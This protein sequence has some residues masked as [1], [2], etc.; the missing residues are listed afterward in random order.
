MKNITK[1]FIH[2][3]YSKKGISLIVLLL[4]I[5]V[6]IILI[7]TI[8]ISVASAID[9]TKITAFAK[10]LTQI[11]ESTESY[12][13]TNGQ[14]PAVNGS[15]IMTKDDLATLVQDADILNQELTENNDTDAQF[16]T[17]DFTKINVTAASTGT[18]ELDDNDIYVVA[19]PS[20][21]VYYLYGLDVKNTVYY[22]LTADF[23][24][25]IDTNNNAINDPVT[26]VSETSG[27]KV[28]QING[29][30]N[31]M[32]V[33]IETEMATGEQLYMSVSGGP[34]KLITTTV[35]NNIFGFNLLSSI[36]NDTETMKVPTL[37]IAEA[38]YIEQGTKPINE[39]YVDIFKYKDGV[40]T[41]KLRI[42]LSNF[43]NKAPAI[44]S[45]AN[46]S[47]LDKNS[48]SISIDKSESGIKE[49]RYE[50][51]TKYTDNATVVNYFSNITDFD[52]TYMQSKAKL[53]TINN[54]SIATISA[55]KEVQSIKVAVIDKA[56]NIT[57]FNQEIAPKLYIGYT[58]NN[59]TNAYV[60]LTANLY[61]AN[62]I[63]NVKFYISTDGVNYSGEQIYTLNNSAS[64]I[65]TQQC[66]PYTNITASN[67]Y[68]K[69]IASNFN[70]T[71]TET[72]VINIPIN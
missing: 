27:I 57:T 16:Y 62:G 53:A 15:V 58:L 2:N 9:N 28:T 49:V 11:K 38:N 59:S 29:W 35:G 48:L 18:K 20:M 45:V 19:F 8:T 1:I 32:G 63:A 36:V 68:I 10:D 71:I 13:M 41:D 3:L 47:S 6:S 17:I 5:I 24:S 23:T 25:L 4:T 12:Y 70:N 21:H 40:Q 14:M 34:M 44:L 46:T 37:T 26:S 66:N 60:Q 30:T 64:G 50:Y 33:N 52:N 39:R 51:L 7:S 69:I 55:P 67:V 42:D 72:R 31:K 61:S 56:G 54:N 22:T 65:I 43:S